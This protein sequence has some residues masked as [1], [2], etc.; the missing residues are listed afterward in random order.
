LSA[1][2]V[3]T[4]T[5]SA[6]FLPNTYE[7]W[8]NTSPTALLKRMRQEFDKFWNEERQAKAKK[9]GLTP[10]EV[11]TLASIVEK[12]TNRNDE[13]P[14]VAGLYANR[15]KQGMKLQSD[16]TVIYGIVQDNPHM[17]ITRVYYK[18]LR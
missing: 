3:N 2:G 14:T 4:N 9:L 10:I 8:W 18:H 6:Y 11:V 13:K 15:I 17:K 16:P 5:V 12:E 1:F 7:L